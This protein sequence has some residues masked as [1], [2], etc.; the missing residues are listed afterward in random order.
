MVFPA[1]AI[2]CRFSPTDL[3]FLGGDWD[4]GRRT[5]RVPGFGASAGFD[6]FSGTWNE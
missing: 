1:G 2:R 6:G 5:R 3:A 4:R